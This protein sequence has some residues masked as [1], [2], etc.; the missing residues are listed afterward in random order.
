M[1]RDVRKLDGCERRDCDDD[2]NGE[3]VPNRERY[4]RANDGDGAAFLKANR[5]REEPAHPRIEAVIT[6]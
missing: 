2:R 1:Y 5:N 4:D 3:N 6:A